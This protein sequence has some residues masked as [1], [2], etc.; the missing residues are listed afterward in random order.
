MAEQRCKNCRHHSKEERRKALEV[1]DGDLELVEFDDKPQ[2]VYICRHPDARYK[3]M[4]PGDPGEGCSLWEGAQKKGLDPD[5]E[6][7]LARRGG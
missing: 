4:G 7:L 2:I 1:G 3:E 5:L 6:R